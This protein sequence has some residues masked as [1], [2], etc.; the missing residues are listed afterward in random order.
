[1]TN[2]EK[3]INNRN[4]V[5]FMYL[6]LFNE[7]YEKDPHYFVQTMIFNNSQKNKKCNLKCVVNLVDLKQDPEE[8]LDELDISIQK[9]LKNISF[10]KDCFESFKLDCIEH[11]TGLKDFFQADIDSSYRRYHY[12]ERYVAMC[13]SFIH[14]IPSIPCPN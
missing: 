14:F 13:N 1:M 6:T 5:N 3:I 12:A 2:E 11:Y 8:F 7:F 9:N 4:M 10:N